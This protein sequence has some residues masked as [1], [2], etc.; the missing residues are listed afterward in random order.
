MSRGQGTL[1]AL[2]QEGF[3]QALQAIRQHHDN[4]GTCVAVIN[5]LFP[6][7]LLEGCGVRPFRIMSGATTKLESL[8]EQLIRPDSCPFCKSLIGGVKSETIPHALA[9]VYIVTSACDQV[10]RTAEVIE[11]ELGRHTMLLQYPMLDTDASRRYFTRETMLLLQQLCAFARTRFSLESGIHAFHQR[12]RNAE[13]MQKL[14]LSANVPAATLLEIS[15]MSALMEPDA[16]SAFLDKLVPLATRPQ[17]AKKILVIG[18]PLLAEDSGLLVL[19]EQHNV[20]GLSTCSTGLA[21]FPVL[22]PPETQTEE[23]FMESVLTSF[24]HHNV[25]VG[26]RPNNRLYQSIAGLIESWKPDGIIL[27]TLSFC[28][29]WFT[30]KVRLQKTF[31]LPLLVLETGF[32]EGALGR[33]ETR[34][35]TF[36]ETL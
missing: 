14:Y 32:G 8:G 21:H 20:Y 25:P 5:A 35:D 2:L 11:N 18:S 33:M 10:R 7:C 36:L 19:L 28:D 27:K 3:K 15:T 17:P 26:R 13:I 4:A 1:P 12:N 23:A 31:D 24:I 29:L 34:I 22:D 9:D 16:F 6:L 30:E